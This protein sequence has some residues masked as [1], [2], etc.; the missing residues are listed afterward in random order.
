MKESN[1]SVKVRGIEKKE[2][3]SVVCIEV[4]IQALRNTN[5][6]GNA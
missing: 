4:M 2:K 3:L 1:V 5:Q 6:A